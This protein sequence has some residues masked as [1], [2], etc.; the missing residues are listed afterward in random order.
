MRLL[1][2]EYAVRNL[3][4]SPL[5]LAM[6]LLGSALVVSLIIA[7]TAFVRGMENSLTRSGSPSNVI[8]LGAGS[9][10]SIERSEIGMSV[11]TQAAA[12]IRG[13]RERMGVDFVSPEVHMALGVSLSADT[14]PVGQAV[15]RGVTPKAF[16]VH[17]Q[18]RIADGRMFHSGEDELII[19][20]LASTRL[21]V[22]DEAVAVGRSIW[23]DGRKL[24]IVGRF[25]A[26]NT[27]MNAELWMPLGNLQIITRRESLSCVVLT[28]EEAEPADVEA[29]AAQRL[30]LELVAMRESDYYR[31]LSAFYKPV[32]GMVWVTAILIALGGIFGGLN[33]M[34]AAFAA[35]V[36]EIGMLQSLGYPRRAIVLSF[37]QESVLA[38]AAGSLIASTFCLLVL[39]GLAVRF[40]MGAFG[41]VLDGTT[42]A[43]G[44]A[45]GLLLG[46]AGSIPPTAQSLRMPITEALKAT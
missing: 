42:M 5:R 11:P 37:V 32:R 17:P 40:S 45:S 22:K 1:P 34:Y 44:L 16:L 2:F 38:A 29:F 9:E 7:A 4:R 21:G 41:L 43:V 12:S 3:G 13:L 39:D 15:V 30:D 26:P 6:S 10:E 19:G 24:K 33:T 46:L 28:L 8:L 25:E 27:V 14:E 18:L 20:E 31:K 23:I 35:R 36:R